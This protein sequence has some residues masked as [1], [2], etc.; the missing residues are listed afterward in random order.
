MKQMIT[1][2]RRVRDR[3]DRLRLDDGA[4]RENDDRRYGVA[5]VHP[6]FA[7]LGSGLDTARSEKT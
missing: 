6:E 2:K 1:G 3:V 5:N 4:N 7:A